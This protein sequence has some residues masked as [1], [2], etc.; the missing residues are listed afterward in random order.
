MAAFLLHLVLNGRGQRP[1]CPHSTLQLE[2]QTE[3]LVEEQCAVGMR[4]FFT[5][6]KGIGIEDEAVNHSY[7]SFSL[8]ARAS[9][10]EDEAVNH[11]HF[12]FSSF[13]LHT[14]ASRIEDEAVNHSVYLS[15]CNIS[16][17]S[18]SIPLPCQILIF[19]FSSPSAQFQWRSF[20]TQPLQDYPP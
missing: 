17:S 14:R 15:K 11:S 13:S 18:I 5:L 9:R 12:S 10:I 8:H 2:I 3:A 4:F 20:W 6:Y 1:S 19:H 7:F 16:N